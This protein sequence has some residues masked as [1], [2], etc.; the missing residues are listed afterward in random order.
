[1]AGL[2]FEMIYQLQVRGPLPSTKGSPIG[3]RAWWE[4]SKATL[5]GKRIKAQSA[6]PGIDWLSAGPD[7]YG[8]PNVRLP[9]RTDD[10]AMVLLHYTGL[11][12][13]NAAF[14]EAT[15]KGAATR[16]EDHYMRMALNFET[17][18]PA[19]G[20]LNQ[21]LFIAEGRLAGQN[22]LEYRVYRVV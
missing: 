6:M 2:E 5:D 8:R 3:E 9:F 14:S 17:G 19:Y 10:G 22:S 12:Q 7:G 11:V 4:M 20:W 16:F 13:V 15:E 21:H 18:D 1:M